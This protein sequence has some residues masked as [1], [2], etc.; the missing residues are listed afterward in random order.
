MLATMLAPH[1]ALGLTIP[2]LGLWLGLLTFVHVIICVLLIFGVLLQRRR[3]RR[4]QRRQRRRARPDRSAPGP[5]RPLI[6][7]CTSRR[8]LR[9]SRLAPPTSPPST[10]GWARR[11]AKLSGVTLPP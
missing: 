6:A 2:L 4:H 1:G 11:L 10:S 9:G 7:I 8:K 3:R 5:Y